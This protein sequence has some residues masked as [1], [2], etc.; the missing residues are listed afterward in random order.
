MF[1]ASLYHMGEQ[2]YGLS[3]G[4]KTKFAVTGNDAQEIKMGGA[5]LFHNT[6]I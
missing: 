6:K 5:K 1:T 3:D 2:V 4:H